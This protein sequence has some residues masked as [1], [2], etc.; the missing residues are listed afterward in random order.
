MNADFQRIPWMGPR[1]RLEA[2]QKLE[3]LRV[4]IGYPDRWRDYS[5]LRIARGDALGN[6][7]RAQEFEFQRQRAKIGRP[8]DKDEFYEL[9]QGVEGYHDNPLNVVV[10]TAGILQPPFYDPRV[11][12]AVTYGWTGG[13]IG[14]ELSHAFDDKGHLF[15]GAGNMRDWWSPEDARSYGEHAACF[16]RQYS[17]YNAVDGIKVNGELTLGENI[18]DNGGLQLDPQAFEEERSPDLSA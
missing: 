11:D 14:H 18:A 8:V 16:V 10:F 4:M 7:L 1:T 2:M 3:Q 17:S 15:D 12:E 9:P 13:V 5:G 6:A